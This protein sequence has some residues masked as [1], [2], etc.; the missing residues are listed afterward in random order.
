MKSHCN[1]HLN[2][3]T[4]HQQQKIPSDPLFPVTAVDPNDCYSHLSHCGERCLFWNIIQMEPWS[5]CS[6]VS[7]RGVFH[8][9]SGGVLAGQSGKLWLF[10]SCPEPPVRQHSN[11]S[12]EGIFHQIM[13]RKQIQD[14]SFPQCQKP[15]VTVHW[16]QSRGGLWRNG[17]GS[18]REGTPSGSPRCWLSLCP[19]TPRMRTFRE[20]GFLC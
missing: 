18:Q 10:S 8:E 20:G 19:P 14:F 4:E 11:L 12:W 7:A 3:E 9:L 13:M 2:Q 6:L 5:L 15:P 16:K 1:Q 17:P